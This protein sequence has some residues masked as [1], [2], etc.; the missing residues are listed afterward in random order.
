MP[1]KGK[2]AHYAET[3]RQWSAW[4]AL[5][6]AGDSQ[7]YDALL[8]DCLPFIAQVARG[9]RVPADRVDDVVQDVLMTVHRARH[10][11][12]PSRPF[13]AWLR[14]IAQRRAI[15]V[16]RRSGRQ[17]NREVHAPLAYELHP[18]PAAGPAAGW[19][20][21]GLSQQIGKAVSGLSPGQREAVEQLA[22]KDQSLE[23]AAR[24]TGRSKGALKVNLHRALSAL[25]RQLDNK[26]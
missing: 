15:D 2:Q 18:D 11:Y 24:V 6:Q 3:D 16:L 12:D 20:K 10:T 9:Q 21:S 13:T 17:N 1:D 23:Q 26:E 25:R 14:V 4:M 19:E 7:A 22:L 8:R 5:A